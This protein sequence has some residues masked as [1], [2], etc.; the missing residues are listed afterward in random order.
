M[1]IKGENYQ[2]QIW[3]TAGEERYQSIAPVYCHGAAGIFL[4]FDLRARLTLEQLEKWNKCL[5]SCDQNVCVIVVGNKSDA[6]DREV[7]FEEGKAYAS[8]FHYAYVETSALT[9]A[10]VDDAFTSLAQKALKARIVNQ[11]QRNAKIVDP[12]GVPEENDDK[13][14]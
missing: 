3:D 12:S 11:C 6:E 10:G 14:C 5:D 13:C 1:N 4:V 7:K 2:L 9:G 8:K